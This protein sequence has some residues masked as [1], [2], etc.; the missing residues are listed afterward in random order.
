MCYKLELLSWKDESRDCLIKD[1]IELEYEIVGCS[2][3]GVLGT[4]AGQC[5]NIISI[6][7]YETRY[8]LAFLDFG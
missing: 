4:R 5:F 6:W 8:R 7:L 3:L 1:A 2:V